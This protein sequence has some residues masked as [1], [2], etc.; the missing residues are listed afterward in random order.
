MFLS[1]H[2]TSVDLV[3]DQ[4]EP[5]M[6]M[7]L[8]KTDV[9]DYF[10][11]EDILGLI[12][13]TAFQLW[14]VIKDDRIVTAIITQFS[15]YPGCVT[16]DIPLVGGSHIDEWIDDVWEVLKEHG[17]QSGCEYIRGFGRKGWTRKINDVQNYSVSWSVKL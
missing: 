9:N 6:Q 10:T 2:P 17:R 14:V 12:K 15:Q 13:S 5:L 3:W 8:D 1:V 7:P 4:V 16:L 11:T